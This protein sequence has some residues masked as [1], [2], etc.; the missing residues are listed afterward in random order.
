MQTAKASRKQSSLSHSWRKIVQKSLCGKGNT[1]P[2]ITAT[3]HVPPSCSPCSGG[4]ECF[5]RKAVRPRRSPHA[6]GTGRRV[7]TGHSR[8]GEGGC[9]VPQQG[10]TDGLSLRPLVGRVRARRPRG[11]ALLH[12]RPPRLHQART[13][14]CSHCMKKWIRAWDS[15][16]NGE[17]FTTPSFPS[18]PEGKIGLP[19]ANPRGRLRSPS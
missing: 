1:F 16:P 18:Q 19:R 9:S 11:A 17:L 10:W 5:G 14:P 7:S 13:P 4:Q 6:A 3:I 15:R 12:K 2:K 8:D